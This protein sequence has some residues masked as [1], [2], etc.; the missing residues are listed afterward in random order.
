[1]HLLEA[2]D[3]ALRAVVAL[4]RQRR[5][6]DVVGG[7][8]E[9]VQHVP[10]RFLVRRDER[11]VLHAQRLDAVGGEPGG[12][13][14]VVRRD[15]R[16]QV[17]DAAPVVDRM[18]ALL[19]PGVPRPGLDGPPQRDGLGDLVAAR[20]VDPA[21]VAEA[22]RE[23][24]EAIR[25]GRG[26]EA[27]E[28]VVEVVPHELGSEHAVRSGPLLEVARQLEV[29]VGLGRVAGTRLRE[30]VE[31]RGVH[32]AV[33]VLP[34]LAGEPRVS[35]ALEVLFRLARDSG[36]GEGFAE[37]RRTAPRSGADEVHESWPEA[38]DGKNT[39]PVGI[40]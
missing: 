10:D 17:V 38:H 28:Q 35:Q 4:P 6:G 14:V 18:G 1:M 9:M 26:A 33:E 36:R 40:D 3:P 39:F 7:H 15:L 22:R 29:E 23:A 8:A 25:A 27:G 11:L 31:H 2:G 30:E 20:H 32:A 24:H 5:V 12:P 34:R 16:P 19:R 37:Q 21:K 13:G